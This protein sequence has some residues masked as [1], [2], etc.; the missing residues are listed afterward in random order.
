[1]SIFG[2]SKEET[3]AQ[4]RRIEEYRK[5]YG[6]TDERSEEPGIEEQDLEDIVPG[7]SILSMALPVGMAKRGA[8]KAGTMAVK[9]GM[10]LMEAAEKQGAKNIGKL[11]EKGA[12]AALDYGAMKKARLLE[13]EAAEEAAPVL[14]YG[15]SAPQPPKP[16]NVP[17]APSIDYF[18]ENIAHRPSFTETGPGGKNIGK[19]RV[20]KE[21]K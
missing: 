12:P 18:S 8:R 10:E 16:S 15:K 5:K 21:S 6:V 14:K 4:K 11:I 7:G 19:L 20:K 13:K 1:M 3:E 2:P 9:A 17:E